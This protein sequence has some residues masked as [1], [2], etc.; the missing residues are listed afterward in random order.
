MYLNFFHKL[1]KLIFSPESKFELLARTLFH[2]V[3]ATRL[4]FWIQDKFVKKS[5]RHYLRHQH[6]QFSSAPKIFRYQPKVTFLLDGSSGLDE[7]FSTTLASL[8]ALEGDSWEALILSPKAVDASSLWQEDREDPRID[9][10]EKQEN[11]LDRVSGEFLIFAQPGDCFLEYLL[12]CFYQHL[13]EDQ[14][15]VLF[16][17]NSEVNREYFSLPQPFFKPGTFSPALLLSI[18]YLSRGFIRVSSLREMHLEIKEDE[19][20]Q[21][22]EYQIAL[23]LYEN[24]G[25]FRHIPLILAS[26]SRWEKPE[27]G[28]NAK[29]I[30]NHLTNQGLSKIKTQKREVGIRF[31]WNHGTPS[32]AIII[33]TRNHPAMLKGLLQSIKRFQYDYNVELNI[34]DNDSDDP[35]TMDYYKEIENGK[36]IKII[37]YHSTFNYS[38][39]INIG[40]A[41]SKS[42]LI[43]LL[44]DDMQVIN[45]NWLSELAQWASLP[46]IG[47]VGAKLMRENHTIQHAGIIMG[48]TGFIGHIY[49]NAPEHYFGLWGSV[50][51]YRNITAVTGACQMMRREVFQ[52]A[53][54]YDEG[55]QLAFGDIDFC[56]R[57][58]QLGYQNIYTPYAQLYHYEGKS[59]GYVT[60]V[61]D[62]LRGYDLLAPY[63]LQED[64]N[65]PPC[66]TYSRIPKCHVQ[67]YSKEARAIL[68]KE[69]KAFYL[70]K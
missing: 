62:I 14:T 30:T 56:C 19:N 25:I 44:N 41:N 45:E 35:E 54:G 39:A 8:K 17:Y 65:F 63:L 4:F 51:W 49:L 61:S 16:Y 28:R 34:V 26:Q 47:V 70:Q 66:L 29:I 37:P 40:V 68:I 9:F 31:S 57:V 43:L 21:A 7:D 53:G 67:G 32:I 27:N 36:G 2:R 69:R 20:L 18:N 23:R 22:Q 60:P 1:R 46:H 15:G 10:V 24:D 58:N 11:I 50:D 33:L 5:Y 38:E 64:P 59:R 48:L 55:Y 12:I 3:S 52:Q 6:E 42:D 13:E